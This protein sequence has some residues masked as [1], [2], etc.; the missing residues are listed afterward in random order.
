[1]IAPL[2]RPA[3]LDASAAEHAHFGVLDGWRA[4]SILLVL[5]G[6]W[7]PIGP[8][9]W[10]LNLAVSN[11]GMVM[12]F[13]LSGFLITNF[14]YRR[15][16]VVDFLLRR[17]FRIVPLA[18]LYCAVV[19]LWVG[20]DLQMWLAHLLF[21]VNVPPFFKT[22]PTDHLWSLCVELHFY[23]GVA[24]LVGL[25]G[26]RALWSLPVLCVGVTAWRV[27]NG[28]VLSNQTEFRLDEILAGATVAL[29]YQRWGEK[30]FRRPPAAMLLIA[31]TSVLL[32]ACGHSDFDM[33]QY[34]RPYVAGLLLVLVLSDPAS[35]LGRLLQG[36]VLAYVA[37]ISF[38]VYVLHGGLA[39][40]WLGGGERLE[41]YLKRP[42]LVAVTWALAHL[43]TF[44]FE[45]R[46]QALGRSLSRR[47]TAARR[48][49]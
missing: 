47:W 25:L 36:R 24:L 28:E 7:F 2:T 32:V 23:I 10:L 30:A 26:K 41:K 14:L 34:A 27:I 16:S 21:Y 11:T 40:T 19:L 22:P 35:M 4:S 13:T 5:A 9:S 44:T 31:L 46:A 29:A 3:E 37:K 49:A 15:P 48:P 1:M 20:A 18:W 42:L 12:F 8:A 45:A 6:H 39:Q 38:A 33:L 43:S 17:L